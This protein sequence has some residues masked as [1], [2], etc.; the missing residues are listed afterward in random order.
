MRNLYRQLRV[1]WQTPRWRRALIVALASD[2]AAFALITAPPVYW[3]VDIITVIALFVLLGFRWSL[4]PALFFEA[5]P[6]LQLFPAWT[7]VVGALAVTER[8]T[9]EHEITV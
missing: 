4:L 9:P 2:A 1:A 8:Q 6:G 7:L 5:I 3:A